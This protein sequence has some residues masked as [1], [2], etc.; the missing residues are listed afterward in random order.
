MDPDTLSGSIAISGCLL[1]ACPEKPI[2]PTDRAISKGVPR[3]AGPYYGAPPAQ[4]AAR[5]RR[6]DPASTGRQARV[7][8]LDPGPRSR[9]SERV[10][11]RQVGARREG[12]Q[13]A[14]PTAVV[15]TVRRDPG[16]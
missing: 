6:L 9:W 12:H 4:G 2:S 15:P 7:L 14:L 3:E 8:R 13:H 10:D 11:G 5:G 1:N 16:A